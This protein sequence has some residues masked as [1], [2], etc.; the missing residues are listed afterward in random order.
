MYERE[1]ISF[2]STYIYYE[3]EISPDLINTVVLNYLIDIDRQRTFNEN[4]IEFKYLNWN[5]RG[6]LLSYNIEKHTITINID[7]KT[8]QSNP[9]PT[10]RSA[11]TFN[12]DSISECVLKYKLIHY[13]NIVEVN[14]YNDKQNR[15]FE[16]KENNIPYTKQIYLKP[17]PKSNIIHTN[18]NIDFID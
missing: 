9:Y 6:T 18:D 10:R 1:Y 17:K 8:Q 12:I 13:K 2:E 3:F 7:Y 14:V 11:E 15:Y 5:V 16:N 4:F